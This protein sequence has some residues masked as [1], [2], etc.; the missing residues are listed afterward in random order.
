[1]LAGLHLAN[2]VLHPAQ[3]AHRRLRRGAH[4]AARHPLHGGLPA[5]GKVVQDP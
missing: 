1:L 4:P 2:P 5:L 3:A